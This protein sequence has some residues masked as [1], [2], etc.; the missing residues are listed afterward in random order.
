MSYGPRIKAL[1][2]YLMNYQL[3]PYERT[4]E[5]LCDLFGERAPGAGTLYSA[6]G[7][8]FEELEHTE[9]E[10]KA[11]LRQAQVVNFDE[12]GLRVN[13]EGMWVHVASTAKLTHYGLHQKR[14]SDATKEIRILPS[15]EGV[16]VHDGLSSYRNYERCSHALCNAHHLR[17]LI[18]V[19]E[20]H[21][22]KWATEMKGLLLEIEESVRE[23]AARGGRHLLPERI[24]KFEV[25]Y[26]E[27]LAAGIKA[28]PPPERTGKRGRPKQSKGK[29]LVDRLD[30]HREA[31]LRF[32]HDFRV[33]FDNNQAERDLRMVKVKQKV[34]GCFR[35]EEGAGAFLRIRGY[36]S[37]VRKQ[38]ENVLAA[39][40]RVFTG[41]PFVLSLQAE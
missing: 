8:C 39:L 34:S 32:M 31:V 27:L 13:G 1:S 19:E 35:T 21:E 25:R 2:V 41:D 15:F 38:G 9:D 7:S 18:F 33:P 23:Q 16:A 30:K 22:Q 20:E 26:Q 12:T 29:N 11:G 17:E 24:E 10:I 5:L 28:N 4:S 14:G 36:I 37:T 6:L 3:L 40:E